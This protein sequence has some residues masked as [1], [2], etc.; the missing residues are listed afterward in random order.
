MK[1]YSPHFIYICARHPSNKKLSNLIL[2]LFTTIYKL[3]ANYL[4]LDVIIKR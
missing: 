2:P 1:N 4:D 3:L